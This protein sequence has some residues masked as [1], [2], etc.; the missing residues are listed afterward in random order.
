M[1]TEEEKKQKTLEDEFIK[2]T[3]T[4]KEIQKLMRLQRSLKS[5]L[6][7]VIVLV[8]S[9]FLLFEQ[10]ERVKLW[11]LERASTVLECAHTVEAFINPK[12]VGGDDYTFNDSARW[13]SDFVDHGGRQNFADD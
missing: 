5:I 10:R 6:T 3:D 11:E 8:L 7:F 1:G 13:C 12:V 4:M 2:A 9:V